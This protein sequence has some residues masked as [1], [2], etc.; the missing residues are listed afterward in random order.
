MQV[1][2]GD[3]TTGKTTELIRIAKEKAKHGTV[4]F[5][6]YDKHRRDIIKQKINRYLDP[7]I[8]KNIIVATM[9]EVFNRDAATGQHI[10][11]TVIDDADEILFSIFPVMESGKFCTISINTS[12]KLGEYRD[13]L[14]VFP[15]RNQFIDIIVSFGNSIFES[16]NKVVNKIKE[17]FHHE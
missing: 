12:R 7:K 10:C 17:V 1:V 14:M 9:Y 6:T 16:V 3:R 8:A 11:Y 13:N 4:L 2:A 15:E 5:I